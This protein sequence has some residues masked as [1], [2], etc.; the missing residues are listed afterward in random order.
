MML[1]KPIYQQRGCSKSKKTSIPITRKQQ[2]KWP[3]VGKATKNRNRPPMPK[4][5]P[6]RRRKM[7]GTYITLI[8]NVGR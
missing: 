5:E 7:T 8:E 6:K 1:R 3:Q 2:Q 4:E